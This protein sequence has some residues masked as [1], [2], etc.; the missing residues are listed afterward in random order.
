MV[1]STVLLQANQTIQEFQNVI[2][3]MKIGQISKNEAILCLYRHNWDFEKARMFWTMK[4][5]E[6][7]ENNNNVNSTIEPEAVKVPELPLG[8]RTADQTQD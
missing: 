5:A 4:L 8:S 1:I 3:L 6:K 7:E 2:E